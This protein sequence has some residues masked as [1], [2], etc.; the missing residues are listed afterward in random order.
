MMTL[1]TVPYHFSVS[2]L[3]VKSLATEKINADR[4]QN[5]KI[6]MESVPAKIPTKMALS[7][8]L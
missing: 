5:T 6:K 7:L 2:F 4:D 8:Q 1:G 3:T